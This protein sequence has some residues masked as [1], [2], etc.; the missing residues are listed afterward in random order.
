MTILSD[1]ASDAIREAISAPLQ[2]VAKA[3]AKIDT[4]VFIGSLVLIFIVI[5]LLLNRKYPAYRGY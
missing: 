5:L 3:L 1:N 4:G 2:P